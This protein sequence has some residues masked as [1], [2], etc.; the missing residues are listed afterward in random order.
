M[1][2]NIIFTYTLCDAWFHRIRRI[3]VCASEK[4]N[5]ICLDEDKKCKYT[6][7]KEDIIKIKEIVKKY[8]CIFDSEDFMVEFSPVLD[9]TINEF[10]FKNG[11][12]KCGMFAYNLWYYENNYDEAPNAALLLAAFNS[13][14]EIL[15]SNGVDSKYLGLK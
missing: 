3:T 11:I 6:I 14:A 7:P 12:K 5:I 9:G 10:I 2:R 4:N 15:I 8:Y 1:K 13:I